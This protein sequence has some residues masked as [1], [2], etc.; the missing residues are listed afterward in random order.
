MTALMHLAI[1][2]SCSLSYASEQNHVTMIIKH[3]WPESWSSPIT[4]QVQDSYRLG[5]Q[6]HWWSRKTRWPGWDPP[7]GYCHGLHHLCNGNMWSHTQIHQYK[8]TIFLFLFHNRPH[9]MSFYSKFQNK[10]I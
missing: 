5:R 2:I 3:L 9:W 1:S 4:A 10:S 7:T 8:Q 6:E